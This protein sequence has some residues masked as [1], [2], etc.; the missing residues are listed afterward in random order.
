MTFSSVHRPLQDYVAAL[1][2]AGLQIERMVEV[3]DTT[4]PAGDRWQ[5]IPLFL[6]ITA[7]VPA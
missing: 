4:A 3:G 6:H 2:T 1:S 5:R 7:A